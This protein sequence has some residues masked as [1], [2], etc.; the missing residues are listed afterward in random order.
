[1]QLEQLA[2]LSKILALATLEAQLKQ[3]VNGE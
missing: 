1:M 2:L 3:I